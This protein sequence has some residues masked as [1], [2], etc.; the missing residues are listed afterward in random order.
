M[1]RNMFTGDYYINLPMILNMY[2]VLLTNRH[3]DVNPL[4]KVPS[5]DTRGAAAFPRRKV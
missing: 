4:R 3:G 2:C 1:C 5:I